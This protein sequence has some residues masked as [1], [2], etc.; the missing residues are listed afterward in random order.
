VAHA[1]VELCRTLLITA[2]TF[3]SW[4][5]TGTT[6]QCEVPEESKKDAV[7]P[8]LIIRYEGTRTGVGE[9]L[10]KPCS[11]WPGT[12]QGFAKLPRPECALLARTVTL[13]AAT[14]PA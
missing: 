12:A 13:P 5:C 2:I 14:K 11:L 4:G 7:S 10:L 6:T 3:A 1:S 8:G 9:A